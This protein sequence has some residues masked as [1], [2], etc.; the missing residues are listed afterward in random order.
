MQL[1]LAQCD[2]LAAQRLAGQ[3]M[4]EESQPGQEEELRPIEID[5]SE[6]ARPEGAREFLHNAA[7]FLIISI[8]GCGPKRR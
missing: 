3:G 7:E 2:E 5:I 6:N 1:L 4:W 8:S